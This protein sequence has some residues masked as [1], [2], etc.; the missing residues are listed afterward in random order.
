[1][2]GGCRAFSSGRCDGRSCL[3][4]HAID[5]ASHW[6]SDRGGELQR[7]KQRSEMTADTFGGHPPPA[8]VQCY[9]M[10]TYALRRVFSTSL[11]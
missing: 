9:S 2:V 4:N 8:K 10:A 3:A 6:L 1:M 7:D 11:P 5:A